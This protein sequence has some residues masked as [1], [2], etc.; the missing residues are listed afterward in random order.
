MKTRKL[1]IERLDPR[2]TLDADD[3]I[4][5]ARIMRL[6]D[7]A[8]AVVS[9]ARIDSATDVDMYKFYAGNGRVAIDIDTPTN[10]APGLGSYIRVFD[11]SGRQ[12]AANNDGQAPNEPPIPASRDANKEFFDSY[13]EFTNAT[14]RWLFVGVSNWQ[15]I[16]Y[17]AVNGSGDSSG[18][19]HLTGQYSIEVKAPNTITADRWKIARSNL[20]DFVPPFGDYAVTFKIPKDASWTIRGINTQSQATLS[21]AQLKGGWPPGNSASNH[22]QNYVVGEERFLVFNAGY[23]ARLKGGYRF[24]SQL[25][26]WARSLRLEVRV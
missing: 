21:D 12:I 7:N 25:A 3:T 15:N 1:T 14:P 6:T 26:D 16:R 4:A 5:E 18:N 2:L 10:G 9:G 13:R 19:R 23:T 11:S 22:P 17:N 8:P 24:E 20:N